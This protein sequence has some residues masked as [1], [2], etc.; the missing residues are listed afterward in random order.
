[1]FLTRGKKILESKDKLR[2]EGVIDSYEVNVIDKAMKTWLISGA[3]NYDIQG[4][5]YSIEFI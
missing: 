1:L 5:K 3:P 4:S 2:S